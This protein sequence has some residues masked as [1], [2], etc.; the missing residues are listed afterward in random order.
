VPRG[1]RDG[2]QYEKTALISLF[3]GGGGGANNKSFH[4][5]AHFKGMFMKIYKEAYKKMD[6]M[7]YQ[8]TAFHFRTVGKI[9]LI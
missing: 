8:H 1:Q 2:S 4:F 9:F 3:N 6:P 5:L 7:N